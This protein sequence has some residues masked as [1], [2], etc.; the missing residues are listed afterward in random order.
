MLFGSFAWLLTV[1]RVTPRRGTPS[2]AAGEH[3]GVDLAVRTRCHAK[4]IYAI[5]CQYS[6]MLDEI[7]KRE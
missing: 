4:Q 2:S 5:C 6:C 3:D 1:M 7:H